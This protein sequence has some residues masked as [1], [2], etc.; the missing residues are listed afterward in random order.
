MRIEYP[1]SDELFAILHALFP[2]LPDSRDPAQIAAEIK[3][4]IEATV[5][6]ANNAP[7][8][9]QN[10][11][12]FA[13]LI[14]CQAIRNDALASADLPKRLKLLNWGENSCRKGPIVV[15][16]L[17]LSNL[18]NR[19]AE[20]GFDRIGIDYEHQSVPEHPNFKA[21]PREY[22]AYGVP[23]VLHGDGLYLENIEWTPSGRANALNY[24]DLSPTL[25]AENG[26]V[27]FLH[28]V[29]LCPQGAVD[30]LS[31]YTSPIPTQKAM[32][33][34]L[35]KIV[36]GLFNIPETSD[37]HAILA[38]ARIYTEKRTSATKANLSAL[39]A[40]MHILSAR[41]DST[42]VRRLTA[43]DLAVCK[44]LGISPEDF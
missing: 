23:R 6:S 32:N 8:L 30:G 29:A 34:E 24:I 35:V 4:K 5:Y 1:V 22:A 14:A 43:S 12:K 20:Y 40:E 13:G 21:A 36:C 44:Q 25:M 37:A 7:A 2:S 33:P 18:T 17:T 27:V 9:S 3:K 10:P 41:L 15:G 11:R 39:A 26:E 38:A 31:F 28:S 16:P 19:Q 42:K